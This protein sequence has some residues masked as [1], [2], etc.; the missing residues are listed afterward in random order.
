MAQ[1]TFLHIK[2]YEK[3]KK[4][5]KAL[6]KEIKKMAN[7]PTNAEKFM[8]MLQMQFETDLLVMR[9]MQMLVPPS[10]DEYKFAI[11]DE[12]GELN[13]ELKA[14]WCWWKESQEPVNQENLLMELVDVWHFCLSFT[15][16]RTNFDVNELANSI[17]YDHL[18]EYTPIEF[19]NKFNRFAYGMPQMKETFEWLIGV[20]NKFGFTFDRV[21]EAYKKKNE[22]NNAR[23]KSNY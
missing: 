19:L 1:I 23:A 14:K 8:N 22:E 10:V 4:R 9:K 13:H 2:T 15:N 6:K 7:K 17:A 16:N 20:G 12:I 21:Y 5:L 11:I 3:K 18:E